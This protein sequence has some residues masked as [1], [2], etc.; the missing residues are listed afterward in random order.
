MKNIELFQREYFFLSNFYY[1]NIEYN[2]QMY[3]S[4]E[5]LFQALKT[6]N[7]D[8]REKIRLA[9]KPGQAKRL[10]RRVRLRK[11]WEDI[12]DQV[13][14]HVLELKFSQ[15]SLLYEKLDYTYPS[16]L[17]EGNNWHDN[18]WGDCYCDKCKHIK[19]ENKLGIFLMKLR[20]NWRTI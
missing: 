15:N 6:L 14:M 17:I 2:F 10:G 18:Y 1:C 19:G 12:K 20:R 3:P 13:M 16:L 5:H 9:E 8:E 4:A 7:A 11:D